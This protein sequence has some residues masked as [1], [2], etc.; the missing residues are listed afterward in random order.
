MSDPNLRIM[1]TKYTETTDGVD[2]QFTWRGDEILGISPN[3]SF[4]PFYPTVE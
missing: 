4:L 3:A 1:T 2:Y